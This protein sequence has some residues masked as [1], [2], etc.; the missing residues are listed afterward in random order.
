[1]AFD[2]YPIYDSEHEYDEV[3]RARSAGV[4][5]EL[6]DDLAMT[7]FG[8]ENEIEEE[9]MRFQDCL[10]AAKRRWNIVF[11]LSIFA[12]MAAFALLKFAYTVIGSLLF[13]S[14]VFVLWL[15]S[16]NKGME[17]AAQG[18]YEFIQARSD[19]INWIKGG[20]EMLSSQAEFDRQDG[21]V[22]EDDPRIIH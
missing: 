15:L 13:L 8:Y 19:H 7:I 3:R 14:A 22:F 9:K 11:C 17:E 1:M 4:G 12:L 5:T 2:S 6:V 20:L 16:G 18:Y 21:D 10:R